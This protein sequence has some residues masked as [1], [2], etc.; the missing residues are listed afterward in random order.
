[1]RSTSPDR[2]NP[3]PGAGKESGKPS[4]KVRPSG[5]SDDP[6]L[7]LAAVDCR[8]R[9][10]V[11][12]DAS[13]KWLHTACNLRRIAAPLVRRVPLPCTRTS[14]HQHHP[15][16]ERQGRFAEFQRRAR[17]ARCS[18]GHG[19]RPVRRRFGSRRPGLGSGERRHGV[20]RSRKRWWNGRRRGGF[21]WR[22]RRFRRWEFRW[23]VLGRRRRR[24]LAVDMHV[25]KSRSQQR[26]W[27]PGR[28]PAAGCLVLGH[29]R[30]RRHWCPGNPDSVDHELASRSA[31]D[32]SAGAR[33]PGGERHHTADTGRPPQPVRLLGGRVG[34]VAVGGLIA[35]ARLFR[36]RYSRNGIRHRGGPSRGNH[37]VDR[38][39]PDADVRWPRHGL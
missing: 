26:R 36:N 35:L 29:L 9:C 11:P 18:D 23:A 27:I 34:H 8:H 3:D 7:H 13:S 28:R 32:R 22:F 20:G 19:G 33:P 15:V 12:V 14:S 4:G 16:A 31:P 2:H 6:S 24:H 37:M 21:G 39:R 5:S 1:M 25:H 10:S 30:R 38:R 17:R